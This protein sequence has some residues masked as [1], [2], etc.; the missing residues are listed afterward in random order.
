M[1]VARSKLH[2]CLS[3]AAVNLLSPIITS[4]EKVPHEKIKKRF[5]HNT[6]SLLERIPSF[7]PDE[8]EESDE[9]LML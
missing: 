1:C 5:T 8:K 6:H 2:H 7:L 3:P 9:G 4:E